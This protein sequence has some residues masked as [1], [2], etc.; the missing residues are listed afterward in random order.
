[1]GGKLHLKL[2]ICVS[3]G[4]PTVWVS[5]AYSNPGVGRAEFTVRQNTPGLGASLIGSSITEVPQAI[6]NAVATSAVFAGTNFT[7]PNFKLPSDWRVQLAADYII[8][9]PYIGDDVSWTTEVM[10]KKPENTA[11]WID[12]SLTGLENGTTADGGRILY[13]AGTPSDIM[14]TNADKE[15][16]SIVMSTVL[17]KGWDNGIRVTTSYTNQDIT[18]AH[19]STSA[20]AGSSYGN[21][22]TI[23]RNVA[24]VGRS[25]YETEHRFVVNF[26][27]ETELFEGYNT[28]VNMFFERRSGKPITYTLNGGAAA[29]NNIYGVPYDLLSPGTTNN[30]LLA[31][32]PTA[33]DPN[34]IF[35]SDAARTNFFNTIEAL[36]LS[37]YAGGYAPRGANTTPWTTTL[38]LSLRQEVPGF[39]N[40]H[41]GVFYV[42][43]AN[44][45][46]L[47]DSSKGKVYGSDFG[48]FNLVQFAID[49]A[50]KQYVYGNTLASTNNYDR[51][52]NQLSTWRLKVGVTYRF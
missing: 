46:N 23:N 48:T 27:Y 37:Q 24:V 39:M 29:L 44:F 21:N 5:N 47:L 42:T 1:L 15:G 33:N 10:Y 20:T 8:N 7:D 12:A 50:T 25:A 40:D 19:T 28:N 34:V 26:G 41:K 35:T 13:R 6:Q 11:Y 43:I 9:I 38:D 2:N 31:Y 18:D 52:Y 51:F 16:R 4:Q 14:L 30:A 36:G 49:P 17:S 45:L 22:T 32:I 3:G